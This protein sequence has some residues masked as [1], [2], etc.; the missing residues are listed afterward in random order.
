MAAPEPGAKPR[1]RN[2]P[3]RRNGWRRLGRGFLIGVTAASLVAALVPG[4]ARAVVTT[5]N[6]ADVAPAPPPI[7]A[8][9]LAGATPPPSE[10]ISDPIEPAAACGAWSL[11]SSYGGQWPTGS[12]WWEYACRYEWPQCIGACNAD[13]APSIWVDHFYWD[14]SNAVFYGEFFGDYYYD[15]MYYSSSCS[16][17][18]DEPTTRWYR[19]D[20]PECA[21]S[22]N[23]APAAELTF[24]CAGLS[25][26]FDGSA[27]SDSDGTIAAYHWDF[28]D[29]MTASGATAGHTYAAPAA[30]PVTLTVT[31]DDGSTA[32]ASTLVSVTNVAPAA[33]FKFSCAGLSCSFDGS[34]SSDSDGTIATYHW[35]FGDG[36]SANGASSVQHAYSQAGS[37]VVTVKVTDNEGSTASTSRVIALISLTAQG[38]K[39]TGRQ[40]VDLSWTG[41]TGATFYVFRDG[42][43]IAIVQASAY[44]DNLG[45][46]GTG[47]YIY[48][49][50]VPAASTCSNGAIVSF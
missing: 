12:T 15:S 49:V 18:W 47:R 11:Q 29:G 44:T 4:E 13:W 48:T 39:V 21:S 41:G 25:C 16:Y 27:S 33:S 37:Y 43:Q 50:C 9:P 31:D 28:G 34:E 17:W 14:G 36:G 5:P 2:G 24:S 6:P 35:D 42:A 45:K 10:L 3:A 32:V 20:T 40:T 23:A 30:Y 38:H 7:P 8:L 46:R 22:P 1:V 19:L 26:S